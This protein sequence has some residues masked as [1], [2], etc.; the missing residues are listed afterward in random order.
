MRA[1]VDA[2]RTAFAASIGLAGVLAA[3]A[4]ADALFESLNGYVSKVVSHGGRPCPFAEGQTFYFNMRSVSGLTIFLLPNTP[5]GA[6]SII[7]QLPS[8]PRSGNSWTGAYTANFVWT[9]GSA[10]WGPKTFKATYNAFSNVF[11]GSMTLVGVNDFNTP[12]AC[13]V[14]ISYAGVFL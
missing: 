11:L 2:T 13:D 4:P 1:S 8:L 14:T 12:N 10:G 7:A 6:A 9:A 5:H 3:S